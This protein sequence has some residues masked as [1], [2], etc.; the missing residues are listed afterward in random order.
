MPDEPRKPPVDW[1]ELY[2]GRFLKGGQLGPNARPILTIADV[3]VEAL[4]GDD[5]KDK[6]KGVISFKETQ[7]QLPLNKT[8]GT[9][10]KA[11][12]GREVPKWIGRQIVLFRGEWK[13]E[14]AVR[15]YGSPELKADISVEVKLPKRRPMTF[16]MHAP[17]RNKPA[18]PPANGQ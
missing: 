8:N 18:G 10:L 2:P 11:M 7:L 5:G 13:G 4:M 17:Q 12:F 14:P 3:S 15:I 6:D 1:D 16:I 9:C